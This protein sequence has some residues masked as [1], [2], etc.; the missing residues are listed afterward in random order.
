M[1]QYLNKRISSLVA[2]QL[3]SHVRQQY[4]T[5]VLFSEAY[6]EFLEQSKAPQEVI[7]NIQLYGDIDHSVDEFIRYFYKN[8]CADFP[9]N[10]QADKKHTLKHINDLYNRKGSEKAVKLLFRLLYNSDVSFYYPEIQVF[11][12]SGAR[13]RDRIS[14]RVNA[15]LKTMNR[16]I[17]Q[18]IVGAI[19][20]A[21]ARITD[22]QNA[23]LSN[24]VQELFLDRKTLSGNFTPNENIICSLPGQSNEL[25]VSKTYNAFLSRFPSSTELAINVVGL[26]DGTL[27]PQ[28]I[29]YA[30]ARSEEC[31]NYLTS[32]VDF[33]KVLMFQTTGN[34]LT[35]D[36]YIQNYG[37]RLLYGTSRITIILELLDTK[38]SKEYLEYTLRNEDT[39]VVTANVRPVVT[40][41]TVISRGYNYNVGDIVTIDTNLGN[42][43]L[44]AKVVEVSYFSK[45]NGD[46]NLANG[47]NITYGIVKVDLDSFD[48][49]NVTYANANLILR[50]L[51]LTRANVV[52][53]ARYANDMPNL[54]AEIAAGNLSLSY[55]QRANLKAQIGALCEYPGNWKVDRSSGVTEGLIS[56]PENRFGG[57]VFRGRKDDGSQTAIF[58]SFVSDAFLLLLDRAATSKE[59]SNY[60]TIFSNFTDIFDAFEQ[61]IL[62]PS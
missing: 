18:K 48:S 6:Y 14:I 62:L 41:V 50:T 43:Y 25:F 12:A 10:P 38:D 13:Y 59:A 47:G 52:A 42:N 3:P 54:H 7:Q 22:V 56:V 1:A 28:D 33:M 55:G 4:E 8:Y 40:N 60:Q 19:S 26:E 30:V 16:L 11:K 5:F 61:I 36:E 27:T 34:N 20:G 35:N 2:S 29:I 57:M 15:P 21:T 49:T 23:D 17:G 44:N 9:V 45:L 24:Q 37:P 46:S 31:E 53:R 58:N 39:I 51:D 32:P